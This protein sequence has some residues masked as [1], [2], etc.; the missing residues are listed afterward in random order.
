[1]HST[2]HK[3]D[4]KTRS[5]DITTTSLILLK[6]TNRCHA[7]FVAA[8]SFAAGGYAGG[9]SLFLTI[10]STIWQ[11]RPLLL[12]LLLRLRLRRRQ[13]GRRPIVK[14]S[15]SSRVRLTAAARLTGLSGAGSTSGAS[16]LHRQSRRKSPKGGRIACWRPVLQHRRGPS[17][18]AGRAAAGILPCQEAARP[19]PGAGHARLQ[20]QAAPL[21]PGLHLVC[22]RGCAR[23]CG[24]PRWLRLRPWAGQLCGRGRPRRQHDGHR[25][26]RRP[27][28]RPRPGRPDRPSGPGR[29]GLAGRSV[30]GAG[31]I[32]E[33][34]VS[35]QVIHRLRHDPRRRQHQPWSLA[36]LHWRCL[37][38]LP[39]ACKST[40]PAHGAP[41]PTSCKCLKKYV[42]FFGVLYEGVSTC[43]A[44]Q[45]G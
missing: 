26:L 6:S 28:R 1:M 36:L 31:G 37:R 25:R 18:P 5:D 40:H 7:D 12:L 44:G 35:V 43:R 11:S 10:D 3:H 30:G 41:P 14:G 34:A 13:L 29:P 15:A 23:G 19:G 33:H 32:W 17:G 9:N 4:M 8:A 42:V 27:R 45:R 38:L 16:M 24:E 39:C 20:P 2:K 22:S 21:R